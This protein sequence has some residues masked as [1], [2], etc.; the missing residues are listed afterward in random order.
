M[1]WKDEIECE[2]VGC[3][4]N[5]LNLLRRLHINHFS[6]LSHNNGCHIGKEEDEYGMD[7]TLI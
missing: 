7:Q 1:S 6:L 3:V 2:D 5:E 4:R